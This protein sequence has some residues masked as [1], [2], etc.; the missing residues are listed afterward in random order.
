MEIEEM[1]APHDFVPYLITSYL[2]HYGLNHKLKIAGKV[3]LT[4][5]KI[6]RL[7]RN[8]AYI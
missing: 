5:N 8:L 3:I 4:H 1:K 2:N 7:V 6:R